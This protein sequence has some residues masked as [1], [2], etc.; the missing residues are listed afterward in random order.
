MIDA[1]KLST[2]RRNRIFPLMRRL[3]VIDRGKR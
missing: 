3:D 1:L 2:H